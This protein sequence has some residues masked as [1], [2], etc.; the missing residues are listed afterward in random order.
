MSDKLICGGQVEKHPLPVEDVFAPSARLCVTWISH[1]GFTQRRGAIVEGAK[2]KFFN[3][4]A[5]ESSTLKQVEY[6]NHAF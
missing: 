5:G 4:G 3:R 6:S 2:K 1:I